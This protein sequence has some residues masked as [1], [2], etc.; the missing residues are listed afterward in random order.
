MSCYIPSRSPKNS[1]VGWCIQPRGVLRGLLN[2]ICVDNMNGNI[3][4]HGKYLM[5]HIYIYTYVY[6]YMY[7]CIYIY[8]HVYIY[9]YIYICVYIYMYVCTD[10]FGGYITGKYDH[11]WYHIIA[12]EKERERVINVRQPVVGT[13][14]RWLWLLCHCTILYLKPWGMRTQIRICRYTSYVYVNIYIY[15]LCLAHCL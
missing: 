6:K 13:S 10:L 14:R 12:Y 7:I 4:R 2:G 11:I 8:I 9:I 5:V 1:S 15:I 3:W